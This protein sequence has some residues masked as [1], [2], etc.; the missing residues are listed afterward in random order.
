VSIDEEP[1]PVV[2]ETRQEALKE[3]LRKAEQTHFE[4]GKPRERE[5]QTSAL[6]LLDRIER[7]ETRI[8]RDSLIAN[9][10]I[11]EKKLSDFGVEGKV[12][13]VKPGRSSPCT[14]SNRRQA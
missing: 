7:K 10:Q 9:S 4:F 13:E 11:L 8:K 14:S 1:P 5:I 3:K 12:V 6:T 2:E